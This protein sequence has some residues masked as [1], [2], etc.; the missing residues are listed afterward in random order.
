MRA[1][2]CCVPVNYLNNNIIGECWPMPLYKA[3]QDEE[4]ICFLIIYSPIQHSASQHIENNND[5]NNRVYYFL[6]R[7]LVP[8]RTQL[9]IMAISLSLALSAG[10]M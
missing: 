2:A 9:S 3:G 1:P 8:P 4:P 7:L 5:G 6:V 10:W